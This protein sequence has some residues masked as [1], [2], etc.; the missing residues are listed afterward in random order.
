LAG[1]VDALPFAGHGRIERGLRQKFLDG[2]IARVRLAFSCLN[3][4]PLNFHDLGVLS[5]VEPFRQRDTPN[6]I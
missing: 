1:Q 4:V 2:G 5:G 3:R 6:M